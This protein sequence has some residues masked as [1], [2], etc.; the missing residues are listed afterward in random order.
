MEDSCL[1]GLLGCQPEWGWAE[2]GGGGGSPGAG[3]G[4]QVFVSD[5]GGFMA[6]GPPAASRG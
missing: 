5:S 2:G 4:R 3:V 1:R 6:C